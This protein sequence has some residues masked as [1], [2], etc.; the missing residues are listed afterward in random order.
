[1]SWTSRCDWQHLDLSGDPML[2]SRI[3]SLPAELGWLSSLRT[4]QRMEA[5]LPGARV[6]TIFFFVAR[7]KKT[8]RCRSRPDLPTYLP[9]T[10]QIWVGQV[11]VGS[12]GPSLGQPKDGATA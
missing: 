3:D 1:M 2:G 7:M 8:S 6:V 12:R 5:R 9:L 4:P 11:A 10:F